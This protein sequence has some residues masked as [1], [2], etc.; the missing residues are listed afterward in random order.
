MK[1]HYQKQ[2]FELNKVFLE[3]PSWEKE[4]IHEI[5]VFSETNGR[6]RKKCVR[7]GKT[8]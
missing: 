4:N 2:I 8:F 1:G 6:C 5:G 3:F 7:T